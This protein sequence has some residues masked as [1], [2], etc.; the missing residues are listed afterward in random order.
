MTLEER[1][2]LVNQRLAKGY[3]AH[4]PP[5]PVQ[6]SEFYHLTVSYF[7]HKSRINT[8]ERRQQLLDII[9]D[10]FIS[11]GIEINAWVVLPN[12]YHLLV[13]HINMSQLSVLFRSIHGPLARQWNLEDNLTGKVWHSFSDRAI[14]SER[15]YYTT[16]NYIHYNPVKHGWAKSPYDW[17][18]SSLHSYL[19]YHGREWLRSAWVEY[20][21]R[22]YGKGWDD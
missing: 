19:E 14:R 1:V 21:V 12:H 4:S 11:N 3:P 13:H 6:N 16:I 15:H 10:S 22:D 2:Q 7:E 17:S 18:A 5:H 8:Q 9:F 20:P